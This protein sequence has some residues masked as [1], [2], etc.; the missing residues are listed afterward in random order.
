MDNNK[1]KPLEKDTPR[2][3]T[4]R[5]EVK[6]IS[7]TL[8]DDENV[9]S[10]PVEVEDFVFKTFG[11]HASE[12]SNKIQAIFGESISEKV[13]QRIEGY[14]IDKDV[15]REGLPAVGKST[16]DMLFLMKK[17][18]ADGETEEKFATL[19][20][21]E[22]ESSR[23][24]KSREKHLRYLSSIHKLFY[25]NVKYPPR[26][27]VF[28]VYGPKVKRFKPI[29]NYVRDFNFKP[30]LIFIGEIGDGKE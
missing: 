10:P 21:I 13:K 20:L 22:H 18:T 19:L 16:P 8:G 11:N 23:R 3:K 7:I 6:N 30:T 24:A 12:T 15:T 27:F 17:V 2:D 4:T 25:K 26:I 28:I 9:S 1:A 14:V 29:S 5:E